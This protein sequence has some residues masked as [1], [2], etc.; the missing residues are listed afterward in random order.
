MI[1]TD[2]EESSISDLIGNDRKASSA[3]PRSRR[4]DCRVQTEQ[5]R[6]LR[7]R[8]DKRRHFM[9]LVH[10]VI[11]TVRLHLNLPD[12][13]LHLVVDPTQIGKRSR[14]LLAR[15]LHRLGVPT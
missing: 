12:N 8:C 13:T 11:G 6:L 5:I 15:E 14:R 3:L 2:L 4:L 1:S 7:N 9:N 10:R